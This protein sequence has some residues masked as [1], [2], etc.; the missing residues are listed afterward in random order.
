M[1]QP[2]IENLKLDDLIALQ[3]T[4]SSAVAKQRE[5]KKQEILGQIQAL[6]KQ[7]DLPFEEVIRA[8][9]GHAKR[10]KAPALYRNPN[11]P[12]QTW[13]GKGVPPDWFTKAKDP[14]T[15]RID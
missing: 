5:L 9:R 7:Y 12:R 6:V 4:V 11:N 3:N 10:G 15:L 1:K 8:I 2:D 13:S 14:D